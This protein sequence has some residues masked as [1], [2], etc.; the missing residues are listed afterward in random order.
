MTTATGN[1]PSPGMPRGRGLDALFDSTAPP[2]GP[3][4]DVEADLAALLDNEVM[5][6]ETGRSP[7]VQVPY[8]FGADSQAQPPI[9]APPKPAATAP[10]R[11]AESIDVPPLAA[12]AQPAPPA[13]EPGRQLP[14]TKR[15]GAIIMDEVPQPAAETGGPTAEGLVPVMPGEKAVPS[16]PGAAIVEDRPLPVVERTEDQKTIVISRLNQVL[17]PDWQRA[18]HQQ[19][20]A[21]YKQVATEFSSPPAMAERALTLLREA[22]Q[23]MIDSPEEYVNAEYRMMQVQAMLDRVKESRKQSTYYGPRI[24]AYEAVWLLF[25][26]LGL[27]F[28]T[29]L[30]RWITTVSGVSGPALLNINPILNTMFWGGIGGVVGALYALWWHISEQQNFDRNYMM[31][32]LVQPLMGLVLGGITFL[33]LTGGFLILQ[34]DLSDDKA[35]TGARLLPYLTAV[36]L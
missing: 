2:P 30:T 27:I 28:A 3:R 9:G 4:P 6:A 20:D 15:F 19:I 34:V 7:G 24:L 33:I 13:A 8:D 14:T 12:E 17:S 26:L 18:F 5:A 32:Y 31:W 23:L 22:R 21:L 1:T 36:L 35:S 29:P 11:T 10:G 16:A 25:L